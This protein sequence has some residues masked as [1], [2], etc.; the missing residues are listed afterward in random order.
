[1]T[2]TMTIYSI[3]RETLFKNAK[4]KEHPHYPNTTTAEAEPRDRGARG[5]S[6]RQSNREERPHSEV[7]LGES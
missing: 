2:T 1:M 6:R 7:R 4:L 3:L 5:R